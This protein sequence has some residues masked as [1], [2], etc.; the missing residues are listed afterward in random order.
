MKKI[1]ALNLVTSISIS[2]VPVQRPTSALSV[3]YVL[4]IHYTC[5]YTYRDMVKI[6]ATAD[7]VEVIG[8]GIFLKTNSK[9]IYPC[10][11]WPGSGY[12]N[13]VNT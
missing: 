13:V 4:I 5:V 11:Y 8:K 7:H 10:A 9:G 3:Y 1:A 2:V 12:A 6:L